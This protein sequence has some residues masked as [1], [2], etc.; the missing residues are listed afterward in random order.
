MVTSKYDVLRKVDEYFAYTMVDDDE[1]VIDRIVDHK[2]MRGKEHFRI[3]YKGKTHM[4]DIWV[5][6]DRFAHHEMIND[7]KKRNRQVFV[8]WT[9]TTHIKFDDDWFA[10]P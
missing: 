3:R 2:I 5:A 10:K 8:T 4:D 1:L 9:N 7:Y 6:G